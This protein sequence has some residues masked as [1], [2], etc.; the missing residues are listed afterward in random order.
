ML[1]Y[2]KE[3]YSQQVLPT[4]AAQGR[5][6]HVNISFLNHKPKPLVSN[7]SAKVFIDVV[8]MNS[9]S[10]IVAIASAPTDGDGLAIHR[11]SLYRNA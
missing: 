11:K 10:L 2:D 9:P 7:F 5:L 3:S 8:S 6:S 4:G 1:Q